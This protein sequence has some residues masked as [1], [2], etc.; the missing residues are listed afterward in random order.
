VSSVELFEAVTTVMRGGSL[1]AGVVTRHSIEE[2]RRRRRVLV[3]EDDSVN[4]EVATSMLRK[5]GHVVDVVANGRDAVD[6]VRDMRYDLVL[7]DYQMPEMDGIAA[8]RAIRSLP[9]GGDVR[10][11]ALTAFA[12]GAERERCL[13]AG[14]NGYVTKPYRAHELFA[15]VEDWG[16]IA[17]GAAGAVQPTTGP[18]VDLARFR[19]TMRAAGAETAVDGIVATFLE[20]AAQRVDDLERAVALGEPAAVER[21][22]HV[23]RSAAA[24]IGAGELARVLSE[25]ESAAR[26]AD[27]ARSRGLLPA[28]R[29]AADATVAYLETGSA[30]S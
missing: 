5:R 3:A 20:S 15:A 22:A 30:R 16:E 6:A 14:M 27:G 25:M 13:A 19:R 12:S 18:V 21:A 23:L 9:A 8:T 17:T 2:A 4:Q 28:V 24:T 29:A 11:I 7:M 26:A 1:G 10:I